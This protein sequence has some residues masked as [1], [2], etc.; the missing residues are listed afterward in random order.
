MATPRLVFY[1]LGPDDGVPKEVEGQPRTAVVLREPGNNTEMR[2]KV[3]LDPETDGGQDFLN[4]TSRLDGSE[5]GQW[6]Q[7]IV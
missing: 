6:A 5:P 7:A 1:H 4:V 2:L 3:F